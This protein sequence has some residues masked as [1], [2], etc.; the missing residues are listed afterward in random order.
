MRWVH[1]YSAIIDERIRK[2]PKPTN[3]SWRMDE[4]YLKIK[5]K[6]AYFIEPWVRREIPSTFLYLIIV[7]KMPQV[8]QKGSKSQT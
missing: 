2:H 4:T 5:G 7:I 8:L 1:Q 3:D 6:N